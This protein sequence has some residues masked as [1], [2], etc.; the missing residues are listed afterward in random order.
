M[1][2]I[3]RADE[4]R[5]AMEEAAIGRQRQMVE[6][7]ATMRQLAERGEKRERSADD[8]AEVAE[9]RA[10]K[11]LKLTVASVTIGGVGVAAAIMA[12]VTG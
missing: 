2:S 5:F 12:I 3:D 9:A 7:M 11:M 10:H 1:R 6:E 4:R 8:R